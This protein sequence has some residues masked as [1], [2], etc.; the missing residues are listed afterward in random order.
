MSDDEIKNKT[1]QQLK[2]ESLE[3]LKELSTINRT[4]YILKEGKSVSETL[5]NIA[6]ILPDGWQYPEFTTARIRYGNEEYRSKEKTPGEDKKEKLA[7]CMARAAAI[8]YG[9]PLQIA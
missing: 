8:P 5:Q 3:R 1:F 9:R 2:V 7:I 6:Y 4:T